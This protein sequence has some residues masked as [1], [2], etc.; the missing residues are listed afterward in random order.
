MFKEKSTEEIIGLINMRAD[1]ID[2]TGG[3]DLASKKDEQSL[4]VQTDNFDMKIKNNEITINAKEQENHTLDELKKKLI[5]DLYNKQNYLEN[6]IRL[7]EIL[8]ENNDI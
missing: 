4:N 3:V 6:D 2:L 1:N 8:F 5:N 7:I